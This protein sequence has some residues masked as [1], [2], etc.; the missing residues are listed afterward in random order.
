ML[1]AVDMAT[2][3]SPACCELMAQSNA[4]A[5]IFTLIR[6]CNRS[7]PHM[8]IIKYSIEVLLNLT[9]VWIPV[10]H[11]FAM[12]YL[13][14]GMHNSQELCPTFDI[15]MLTR[16]DGRISRASCLL[17]WEIKGFISHG[18]E[19]WRSQTTDLKMF[20]CHFLVRR[21]AVLG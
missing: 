21:S 1:V 6:S 18:F 5:V 7:A 12:P 13:S 9:K 15:S 10:N 3:W 16:H 17:F 8:E 4:A 2:R 14:T 11:A 20:T 19:P